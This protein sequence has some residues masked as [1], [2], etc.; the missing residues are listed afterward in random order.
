MSKPSDFRELSCAQ[1]RSGEA[2]G[3]AISMAFQPIV[4]AVNQRLFAQEALV[5]GVN[6]ESAGQVIA[7]INENNRY[8]F[9]QT[10]RVKAIELASQFSD[11]CLLNINFMPNAIYRPEL[12]IR[13]T[14]NAAQEYGFDTRRIVFE[15]TETEQLRD[16]QHIKN[17]I[18]SYHELGFKTALDDFGAGYSG[19][20][21]LADIQPDMIK[22]DMALIR[23][24]H[25]DKKRQAIVRACVGLCEQIDAQLIAEGIETYEEYAC[26]RESGIDLFQGYYFA[27][28]AFEQFPSLDTRLFSRES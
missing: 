21:L 8:R 23:N 16:V 18:N 28:P 13:T 15:F 6:G 19:L 9:D 5:R 27:K 24:V 2:L 14:L 11:N 22:L 7:Q 20:N 12:C 17:I 26:L 3:F 4:D 10:C 1:C 25:Q